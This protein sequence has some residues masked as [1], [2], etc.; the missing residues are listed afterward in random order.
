MIRNRDAISP[1]NL[2]LDAMWATDI[3]RYRSGAWLG[4]PVTS[5]KLLNR[6]TSDKPYTDDATLMAE[7]AARA[8]V[9]IERSA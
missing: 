8:A 9:Q 5:E 1:S 3:A 7:L 4:G 6:S 2:S